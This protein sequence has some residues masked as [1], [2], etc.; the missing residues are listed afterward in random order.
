MNNL[1]QDILNDYVIIYLNNILIYLKG[2]LEN[3]QNK[4]KEILFRFDKAGFKF[5]L[6]KY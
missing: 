5:K 3:H 2:I 1:F 4:I 6:K